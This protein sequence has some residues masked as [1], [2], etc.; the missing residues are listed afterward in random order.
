MNRFHADIFYDSAGVLVILFRWVNGT[1]PRWG[2]NSDYESVFLQ[3]A[4]AGHNH[5]ATEVCPMSSQKTIPTAK[6]LSESTTRLIRPGELGDTRPVKGRSDVSPNAHTRLIRPGE[7]GDTRPV[8][9][10]VKGR[11]SDR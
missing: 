4:R 6:S 11:K 1:L 3:N 9:R 8:K 2:G 10:R 7:I 5:Y